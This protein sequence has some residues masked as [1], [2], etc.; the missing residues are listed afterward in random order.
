[1]SEL[2]CTSCAREIPPAS[3]SEAIQAARC[4]ACSRLVDLT[5][6]RGSARLQRQPLATPAPERW[7]VED[8]VLAFS[9]SWRWFDLK[10][11]FLIPFMLF[12]NGILFAMAMGVSEGLKHPERLLFGLAVPHVWVGLGLLYSTL[13]N[14]LNSTRVSVR[15]GELRVS[16]GPLPWLGNRRVGGGEL[17]Q[18]FVVEKR[19]GKGAP[20]YELCA[21][22]REGKKIALLSG[23]DSHDKA[24]FLEHRVE[25]ALGIEDR[26]VVGEHP[27][28]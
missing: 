23:I 6:E 8:G 19:G 1:M 5:R 27:K 22:T 13:A 18:I 12:W 21:S 9:A 2:R 24:L 10:G 3:V 15:D 11:L 26:A 17:T 20:S 14:L 16:K 28:S 7:K 4:P 25:R